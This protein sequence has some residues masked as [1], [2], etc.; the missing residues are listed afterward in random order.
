MSKNP[1]KLEALTAAGITVTERIPIEIPPSEL[2][3]H[4]LRTKKAKLGHLLEMV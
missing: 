1:R 4:Y 2:S 3:E